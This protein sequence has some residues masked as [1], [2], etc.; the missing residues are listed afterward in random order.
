MFMKIV[1]I[2][3]TPSQTNGFATVYGLGEDNRVYRWNPFSGVWDYDGPQEDE[4]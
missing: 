3:T 2:A 1:Q 4:N